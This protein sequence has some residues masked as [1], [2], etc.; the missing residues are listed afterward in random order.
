ML[1]TFNSQSRTWESYQAQYLVTVWHL[2]PEGLCS[3]HPTIPKHMMDTKGRRHEY[4]WTQ[5]IHL[6]ELDI[7]EY[8][9][10]AYFKDLGSYHLF[11]GRQKKVH[12]HL[13]K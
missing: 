1:P 9:M 12:Y 4:R 5:F 8:E 6:K 7:M 10:F 11:Y 3:P 13:I 2:S